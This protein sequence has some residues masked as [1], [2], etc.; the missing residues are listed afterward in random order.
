MISLMAAMLMVPDAPEMV[1]V[2]G[3][4]NRTCGAWT[5]AAKVGTLA[6]THLRREFGGWLA[7]YLSGLN[8]TKELRE[9]ANA[10]DGNGYVAWVDS[11]CE[12]NPLDTVFIAAS[13]LVNELIDRESKRK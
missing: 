3:V 10:K 7:G 12:R 6:D 2:I 1:S 4:G 9:L 5:N 11:Y 13:S 8:S